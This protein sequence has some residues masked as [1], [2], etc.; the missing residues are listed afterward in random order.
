[1]PDPP[2]HGECT[3]CQTTR[4]D[5]L[6]LGP[7]LAC[8]PHCEHID[9]NPDLSM[10]RAVATRTN[11]VVTCYVLG[12]GEAYRLAAALTRELDAEGLGP[13]AMQFL[14]ASFAGLL[15]NLADVAH[16][17][18]EA[19]WRHWCEADAAR[20]AGQPPPTYPPDGGPT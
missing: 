3:S 13:L 18:P 5:C 8:C 10:V 15:K 19:Q 16:I 7:T 14:A 2:P 12:G 9:P 6:A 11:Q 17:D 1:V 20:A 4:A